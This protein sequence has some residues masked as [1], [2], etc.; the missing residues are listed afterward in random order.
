M[1]RSV[2][3]TLFIAALGTPVDAAYVVP[4][5]FTAVVR[6]VAAWFYGEPDDTV[7]GLQDLTTSAFVYYV[8]M[9]DEYQYSHWQGRQVFPEGSEFQASST[10]PNTVSVRVSGY[11]L[12][13]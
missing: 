7:L 11:L 3:S 4:A 9:Q 2:Y 12:A 6:D 8:V 5:G 13:A 10:G 1:A